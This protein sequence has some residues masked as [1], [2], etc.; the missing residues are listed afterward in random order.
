MISKFKNYIL[1]IFLILAILISIFLISQDSKKSSFLLDTRENKFTI[2]LDLKKEDEKNLVELLNELNLLKTSI[3]GFSF[4]L[5]STSSAGLAF[6]TPIKSD[7]SVK[8]NSISFSGKTSHSLFLSKNELDTINVPESSNLVLYSKNL[9]EFI[10]NENIPGFR[11]GYSILNR[12]LLG[13]EFEIWLG[14]TFPKEIPG[15]LLVFGEDANLAIV[16]LDKGIDFSSLNDVFDQEQLEESYKVE[17]QNEISYH[18]INT[19]ESEDQ[20]NQTLA[21]F[22][23]D[24][25]QVLAS[26]RDAAFAVAASIKSG[27]QSINFPPDNIDSDSNFALFY[28]NLSDFPVNQNF[29]NLLFETDNFS[30][31]S[32]QNL[33]E[34]LQNVKTL[35]FVLK[36]DEFSGLIEFK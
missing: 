31:I 14:R 28:Q 9:I 5:D 3:N 17:T 12:N 33:K 27:D 30:Q 29:V 18:L 8:N 34:K 13:E 26:S 22:K 23:I 7:F 1:A 25:W 11:S 6:L 4:E 20:A 36:T 16:T 19:V 32:P 24:N 21:L 35:N 2:N 15:Y 10:L